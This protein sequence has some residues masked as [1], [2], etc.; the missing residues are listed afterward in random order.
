MISE[1]S[2]K[3]DSQALYGRLWGNGFLPSAHQ[4]VKFRG[5]GDPVL[6]LSNPTGINPQ[7]RREILDL[8]QA[9]NEKHYQEVGDP[10]TLARI[11]QAELAYRMQT[12]VP[13]LMD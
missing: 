9:L 12:S 4:G 2:G 10:E 7:Q 5:K 11:K 3:R 6:Y 1:G 8:S 13:G